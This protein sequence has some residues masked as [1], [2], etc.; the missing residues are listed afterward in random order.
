MSKYVILMDVSGDI[1]QASV[2][3]WD[4]KFIPMQ[5]SLGEEMR[6]SNGPEPEDVLKL[7]YDGQRNGDLT[8][9]SQITPFQYEEYFEPY[10][11]DGYS[12][13]YLC[14]SSGLSS[15]YSA[16]CL[17]KESLKEKY[18]ELDVYPIDTLAA[19]G[20]MGV[21]AEI[22]LRNREKGLSIEENRDDLLSLIPR[23]RNWFLVQDLKYLKR[24]GRISAT[25]A[26]FGTML[27]I[28][29]ILKID[30]QGKLTTIAKKRGNKMAVQALIDYFKEYY[31]PTAPS[32]VYICNAD[33][34][35]LG[36]LLAEKILKE[37][38][39]IEIKQTTLSPIIGAHTGPGMLILSHVGK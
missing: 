22:A 15:T 34:K 37:F 9:T 12:V 39:N 20:G 25:T 11:K 26:V 5:Y 13:L 24:G 2:D 17:A 6:T 8:K 19:T 36:D 35:D 10:L 38:P 21:L 31:D 23:Q 16:A 33:C 28:K 32:I 1:E 27:N 4:L 3:K 30:D 14:L 29:P 7:F 18:P